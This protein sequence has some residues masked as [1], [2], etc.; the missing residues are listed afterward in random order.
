MCFGALASQKPINEQSAAP[1][2]ELADEM[3]QRA[4][5]LAENELLT[6]RQAFKLSLGLAHTLLQEVILYACAWSSGRQL[7]AD[8]RRIL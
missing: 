7:I 2:Q 4:K 5:E 1:V 6:E 8:A 3:L